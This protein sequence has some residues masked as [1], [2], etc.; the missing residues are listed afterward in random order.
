ML[1]VPSLRLDDRVESVDPRRTGIGWSEAGFRRV[2]IDLSPSALDFG[3]TRWNL[4][5]LI[6]DLATR[7]DVQ[8]SGHVERSED[9]DMLSD[10]GARLVRVGPRGIDDPAWLAA[11]AAGVP[12]TLVLATTARERRIRS[13]GWTRSLPVDVVD[14]ARE[15]ADI[16]L[17]GFQLDIL[18]SL[19]HSDLALIE[20][21]AGDAPWPIIIGIGSPTLTQLRD[22]ERRGASAAIIDGSKMQEILDEATLARMFD[23]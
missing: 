4:E 8:I 16:A 18:E 21:L 9:L 5:S 1:I 23:A 22:L 20:D 3:R 14:L 10:A 12:D 19:D 7:L 11:M 6:A 2:N 17:G 13:R 15:C